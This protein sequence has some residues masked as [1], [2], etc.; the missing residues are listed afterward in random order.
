MSGSPSW[1]LSEWPGGTSL[2]NGRR[3]P[4]GQE[5]KARVMLRDHGDRSSQVASAG[6]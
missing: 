4:I 6:I 2:T 1:A 3:G 5:A